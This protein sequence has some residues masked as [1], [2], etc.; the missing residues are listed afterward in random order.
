MIK[1][2]LWCSADL[3]GI[4]LDVNAPLLLGITL[5]FAPRI[6]YQILVVDVFSGPSRAYKK[7]KSSMIPKE[8][9]IKKLNKHEW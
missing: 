3:T 2:A 5:L 4:R 9:S 6:L 8:V 7:P 1:R